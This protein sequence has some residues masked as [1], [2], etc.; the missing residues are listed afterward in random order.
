MPRLCPTLPTPCLQLPGLERELLLQLLPKD[1]ND[2][3][4][5]VIEVRGW[6]GGQANDPDNQAPTFSESMHSGG[7]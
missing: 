7:P 4:G 2:E 6:G 5:V 3:R 1:S